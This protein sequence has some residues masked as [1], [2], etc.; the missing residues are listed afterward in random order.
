MVWS[1]HPEYL[2]TVDVA[3][4]FNKPIE[5]DSDMY[6]QWKPDCSPE[7]EAYVNKPIYEF[8]FSMKDDFFL[9]I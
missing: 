1:Y 8:I 4:A 2:S 5:K 6:N 7:I 9:S 3:K